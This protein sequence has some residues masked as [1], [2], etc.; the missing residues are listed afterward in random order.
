MNGTLKDYTKCCKCGVLVGCCAD[1]VTKKCAEDC[2]EKQ[3]EVCRSETNS[4]MGFTSNA[5]EFCTDCED[6]GGGA[7]CDDTVPGCTVY[8]VDSL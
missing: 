1:T 7:D 8:H 3:K 2:S 5:R 4:Q 6:Y